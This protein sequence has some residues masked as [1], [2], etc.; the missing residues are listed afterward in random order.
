L[1]LPR[2]TIAPFAF[3]ANVVVNG[4]VMTASARAM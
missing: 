4:V 3:A 2:S 1:A